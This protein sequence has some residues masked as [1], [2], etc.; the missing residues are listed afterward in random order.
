MKAEILHFKKR[1]IR[2]GC[3]EDIVF[4]EQ[5][6]AAAVL[7][8]KGK[9]RS[10]LTQMADNTGEQKINHLIYDLNEVIDDV[11]LDVARR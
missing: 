10:E 7:F 9:L 4:R 5:D 6:V 3:L 11:F 8:L 2:T 1:K